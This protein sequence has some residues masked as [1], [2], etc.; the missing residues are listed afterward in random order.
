MTEEE[1]MKTTE[2]LD[3]I[4]EEHDKLVETSE[5]QEGDICQKS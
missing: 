4:I 3:W 2:D 1:L 5:K